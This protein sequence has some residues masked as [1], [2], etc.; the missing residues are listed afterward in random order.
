MA[1]WYRDIYISFMVDLIVFL[2]LWLCS[3]INRRAVVD[4]NEGSG[5]VF[6]WEAAC[7][8]KRRKE[9][10]ERKEEEER[11]LSGEEEEARSRDCFKKG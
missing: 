7:G 1:D 11:Y 5:R 8:G 9:G 10:R 2:I 4:I 3:A 6:P